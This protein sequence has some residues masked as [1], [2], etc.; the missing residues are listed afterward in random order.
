MRQ[1]GLIG[2]IRSERSEPVTLSWDKDEETVQQVKPAS[3]IETID[4]HLHEKLAPS[5]GAI[6]S[7]PQIDMEKM[8]KISETEPIMGMYGLCQHFRPFTF[9]ILRYLT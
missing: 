8:R 1:E 5:V 7:H 6:D 9:C 4:S 3:P 2:K